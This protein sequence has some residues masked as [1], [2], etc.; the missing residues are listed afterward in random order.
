MNPRDIIIEP[1]EKAT[2]SVIWLHGLGAS[3]RDFEPIIPH[4]PKAVLKHTRFIFPQAPNREI[5]INMGMVMPAWYDIIA[6][7]LTAN[8]DEEGVRDS[9]RLLQTYIAEEIQRGIAAE[10]IVLAG[11]SQ[12]G[13][14]ALQTG[15]RYP[16]KLAGIM[17]LSTYIP[18]A[19]TLESERHEKNNTTPIFYGHG[20]FDSVIMLKQAESSY[21]QLKSLGYTVAWHIYNMEHSVNME[22]IQDIGQWLNKYLP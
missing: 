18:L 13:A 20:Q 2:A 17:A 21:M 14:I 9:E 1:D 12:G 15:L 6:M 16:E 19:H 4:L 3:A 22:E 10:R 8:Q 7:D 5:T 11:F